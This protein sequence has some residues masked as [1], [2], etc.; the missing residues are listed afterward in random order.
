MKKSIYTF[1]ICLALGLT[2]C[3]SSLE[4]TAADLEKIAEDM[5]AEPKVIGDWGLSDFDLGMEIPAEQQEMFDTMKKEMVAVSTMSYKD[6]GTY[7]QNDLMQGE[8]VTQTGTYH[9]V[10]GKLTTIND[11][12]DI[13]STTEIISLTETELVLS[14]ED[15][16][17]T[18]KMTYTRK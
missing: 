3:T 14:I 17:N 10:N 11:E 16:G 1:G 12:T 4:G 13:P 6:D 9:V 8:V 18:I 5:K 15:Q 7:S 2:A